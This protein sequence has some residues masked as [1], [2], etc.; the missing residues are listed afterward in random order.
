MGIQAGNSKSA[1]KTGVTQV[2]NCSACGDGIFSNQ[3]YA[4]VRRPTTGKN[5]IG[6][7]PAGAVVLEVVNPR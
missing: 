5:H 1:V 6:C 4:Q 7:V 2:G 3:V